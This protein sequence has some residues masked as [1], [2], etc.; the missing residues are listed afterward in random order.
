MRRPGSPP[1][2]GGAPP[3]P[4][5]MILSC[6]SCSTRYLVDDA[7]LTPKGRR[8]RCSRCS[9]TWFQEPR[10]PLPDEPVFAVDPIDPPPLGRNVN[11]P[12]LP[13]ESGRRFPI[14]WLVL[15]LAI[16]A[17]IAGGYFGRPWIVDVW[18][19]AARLYQA[20]GL[21][22]EKAGAGLDIRNVVSERRREGDRLVLVIEGNV[23]NISD[24]PL[25]V[26]VL[27]IALRGADRVEL[28]FWT[29]R[30]SVEKLMPGE[31]VSFRT[32]LEKE[33]PGAAS[34]AVTFD[35]K[36]AGRG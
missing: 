13:S 33:V 7:A 8:V 31:S 35:D 30:P 34:I 3:G 20:L 26:P 18:P 16:V 1:N 10:A 29:F 32:Q 17:T 15:V 19:P 27:R 23:T 21:E 12:A 9:H 2:L 6:T 14:G 4:D 28:H 5:P 24:R 22:D 36:A 25:A 11:L